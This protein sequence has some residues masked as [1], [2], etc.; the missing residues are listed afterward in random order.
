MGLGSLT[1]RAQAPAN[2][3]P[4]GATVLTP[5]GSL[6]AAATTATNQGAT[7]T[8]PNGY[9]NTGS[10]KDVW[11]KFTT[12]ASGPASFGATVTVTGNPAGFIQL[13]AAA[14]G[15][16]GPFSLIDF[17]PNPLNSGAPNTA[18][19]RL[20]T[21]VLMPNTT[22]YLRVAGFTD[23]DLTGAFT[24]CVADGPG[25][26]T[27][28]AP[29]LGTPTYASTTTA[30]IPLTLGANNTWPVAV[31]VTGPNGFSQTTTA[32]ASPIQLSGL[33]QGTTYTVRVTAPCAASGQ[34][35]PAVTRSISTPTRYCSTGLGGSCGFSNITDVS[36]AGTTL[37]NTSQSPACTTGG[38]TNFPAASPTTA[39]LQPGTSYSLSVKTANVSATDNVAAWLDFN[40]NGVFEASESIMPASVTSANITRTVSFTIPQTALAGPTGLR[41]RS[42]ASSFSGLGTGAA[43]TSLIGGET[44]DYTVT[45]T[46]PAGCAAP[47]GLVISNLTATT[48]TLSFTP[49]AGTVSYTVTYGSYIGIGNT[50][51]YTLLVT[52]SP[53]QLTGLIASG[54]SSATVVA[55]CGP[56]SASSP[57]T[58]GFVTPPGAPANDDCANA[59]LLVTGIS[60]LPV[61][62]NSNGGTVAVPAPPVPTAA[63]TVPINQDVWYRFVATGPAHNVVV[64]IDDRGSIL[65]DAFAGTCAGFTRLACTRHLANAAGNQNATLTLPLTNLTPGQTYY[66]RIGQELTTAY[67]WPYE[68]SVQ[69]P[70]SGY[71]VGSH[72]ITST[73]CPAPSLTSAAIA[74]TTL[75]SVAPACQPGSAY[76]EYDPSG[77]GTA[78]LLAG[79]TYQLQTTAG[80]GPADIGLWIDYNLNAVFEP[81][82][83]TLVG[84]NVTGNTTVSFTVPAS[85]TVG[86]TRLR[87]RTTAAGAG[88]GAADACTAFT[89][90]QTSDFRI[91]IGTT[92]PN[93]CPTPTNVSVT[94][95]TAGPL[96]G[97]TVAF[98]A[99]TPG[100][101]GT[102]ITATPTGGGTPITAT[103]VSSPYTLTGLAPNTSYQVCV[104]STCAGGVTSL[105]P[106]CTTASTA[107][108]TRPAALA[109][110]VG[111]FPNPAHRT[112]TLAVPAALLHQAAE[113]TLLNSVGQVARHMMVPAARADAQVA[114]DLAHL[115]AGLYLVQLATD[116]GPLVKRL[117]VE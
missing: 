75:N 64:G 30:T 34:T 55:N 67:A 1:A 5:Q 21:G 27:C 9:T 15:C 14:S 86:A 117:V 57:A 103:A 35:A 73:T 96:T 101:T 23:A 108:A 98:T 116:Q 89:T 78:T 59:I 63:C 39:T 46:A 88:L 10:P 37:T 113:L 18:A 107:L 111:L 52:G 56:G 20:T 45:L 44:E 11:F 8:V 79:T 60:P 31:L 25:L 47:T 87:L 3:D 50:S 29:T 106:V 40:Q 92:V 49:V 4:C 82:E 65:V 80:S 7:T 12:A 105:P 58:V 104:A 90:G 99:G 38:Y 76:V 110:L 102:T 81:G 36:I 2:D 85:A 83:F 109:A 16:T 17:S 95:S 97:L 26:P 28:G 42:L 91:T 24:I 68:I 115:P 93:G 32:A 114:L 94:R 6:C 72:G 54:S 41:V 19:Q 100:T 43:C 61:S 66:I 69:Q 71:C 70:N 48:A 77:S 53:V 112:A 84:Q 22:Y 51:I 74:G 33:T 62:G 13:F